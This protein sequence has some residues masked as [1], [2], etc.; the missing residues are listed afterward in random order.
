[1]GHL[2]LQILVGSTIKKRGYP[3]TIC[4]LVSLESSIDVNI[5]IMLAMRLGVSRKL[6]I[7]RDL[8]IDLMGTTFTGLISVW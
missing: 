3:Q 4:R 2:R 5:F 1:M 6:M 8:I 7:K